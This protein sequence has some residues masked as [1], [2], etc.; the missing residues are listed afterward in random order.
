MK[1]EKLAKD[2]IKYVGG[3]NNIKSLVHCSTRLR[4]ELVDKKK[5]NDEKIKALNGVLTLFKKSGQYQLVIGND[6]DRVYQEIAKDLNIKNSNETGKKD[7]RKILDRVLSAI[8]GSIAPV[9]PLLAGVGIGKVL[10]L[11]LSLTGILAEDSQT[12]IMLKFIFDT[13]FYFM[14]A[15]IGFSAAKI[16]NTNQYLGAFLGLCLVNPV[17]MD[18][19]KEGE[20]FKFIG[21]SVP[22]VKY[23]SSLVPA[24]MGVWIMSYVEKYVKKIVPDMIKIFAEPLFIALIMMPLSFIFIAPIGNFISAFVAKGS[25]FLYDKVGMFA[26]AILAAVYPWLVSVGAHKALSPI[27]IAL[28]AE[29]GFDPVIR[30]VALCSDMSQAA[31]ALAVSVKTKNKEQK[32]LAFSSSVSA[33]LGGITEPAMYGVNLKLKTPMYAAMIGAFVAGIFAGIVKLKAFIY[34]TPG[35]LSLAMWVSKEENFFFMAIITMLIA[36]VVTFIATLIIGFDDSEF[37]DEEDDNLENIQDKNKEISVKDG[38]LYAPI[39]G[40]VKKLEEVDDTTFASKVMGDGLAIKPNKGLLRSPEDAEVTA[41]FDS[42]HAICLKC[43]NGM[44]VLIHI[45]IDTVNLKGEGFKVL[46]EVVSKVKKGD[47]LIEFDLDTIKNSGYDYVIIVVTNSDDYKEF[48][49]S[50]SKEVNLRT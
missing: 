32:S 10:L 11:V 36:S 4:F 19:V 3:K 39:E 2:I 45:G 25:M 29:Q 34:V 1:Y 50:D 44:E 30:V 41:V 35:I 24:L 26:I 17:W 16:F 7:E 22:L 48:E 18:I 27:S 46:V 15:F 47:K 43:D 8:T 13:G 5:A 14:P 28:V 42:G 33:F 20:V 12:Y 6:V 9:I 37:V 49:I 23:T 40:R 31:A 21:L 38:Q